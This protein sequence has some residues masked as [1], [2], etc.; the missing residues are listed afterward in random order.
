[1]AGMHVALECRFAANRSWCRFNDQGALIAP[2]SRFQHPVRIPRAE[3][4]GEDPKRRS[5]QLADAVDTHLC[6]PALCL[7]ANAVDAANRKRP[8]SSLQIA[9]AD[10]RDAARLV[11]IGRDF[12]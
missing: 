8:D 1:M 10:Q 12:G 2:M 3:L 9:I 11:E 4:G 6:Q 5:S 7:R